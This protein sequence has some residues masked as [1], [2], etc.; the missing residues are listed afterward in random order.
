MWEQD[1]RYKYWQYPYVIIVMFWY[2]SPQAEQAVSSSFD[3]ACAEW[4]VSQLYLLFIHVVRSIINI[5]SVFMLFLLSYWMTVAQNNESFRRN[6]G[7]LLESQKWTLQYIHISN[8]HA[9]EQPSQRIL[10]VNLY[11]VCSTIGNGGKRETKKRRVC[12]TLW[13]LWL[14]K[15]KI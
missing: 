8:L 3:G 15:N 4:I 7:N 2:E 10:H 11:R 6:N 14:Q 5:S 12:T 9:F 13:K 1:V